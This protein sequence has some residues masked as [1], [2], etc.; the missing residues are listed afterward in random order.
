MTDVIRP[1]AV[2]EEPGR[3]RS[4]SITATGI[5]CGRESTAFGILCDDLMARAGAKVK[6]QMLLAIVLK[7]QH[8]YVLSTPSTSIP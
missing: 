7:K 1:G 4:R 3:C 2:R 5:V 6:N 8:A